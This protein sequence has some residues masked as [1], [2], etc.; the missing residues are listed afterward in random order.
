MHTQVDQLLKSFW[1][2]EAEP[3]YKQKIL[4]A[5]EQ[6]CE[7][8]YQSTTA[9]DE[10]GRY[11]VKLPFRDPQ[12]AC[13]NGN[14]REIA[15][16]RFLSLEKK[17][18]KDEHL[19]RE[20]QKIFKEYVDLNHMQEIRHTP[21][22]GNQNY[23]YLPYHAVVREDKETTKVRIVFDASC[24]GANG[25]SLN[26]DLMV[27]PSLQS[28]LRH[29]IMRWRV[30][31]ICFAADI[32]KMY[33]QVKVD[34][35]DANYQR[36]LWRENPC[37]DFKEYKLLRVTF[38]T[39]SAPYLAVKS[40]MQVAKDEGHNYPLAVERVERDF[41][42][43]D[44]MS[45]CEHEDEAIE[46]YKQMTALLLKGG[47]ELQKWTSNSESMIER[48]RQEQAGKEVEKAI[49]VK[50]ETTNKILGLTWS[51][52]TDEFLYSVQLPPISTPV[53]KRKVIS[54]I[55][56][57]YDPQ[58]WIA[59]S[60]IKA[61]IFIQKLWLAGI[62]WDE[63]V[64][65]VLLEE[66]TEFRESLIQLTNFRLKRWMNFKA[67]V[68]LVELHGF[69]DAST[70]AFGAVVYARIMDA[71]GNIHVSLVTAKTR[72]API[73]QLSIPRLELNGAVLLAK[74]LVEVSEVLKIPKTN[75]HA[76]TDSEVVLAWLS[77]HPSKWKTFIGNRVSEILTVTD[78]K[79]WSHVKSE[80]NPADYASRGLSAAE[81]VSCELWLRGPSWLKERNINYTN[82]K[83]ITTNLE[84]RIVKTHLAV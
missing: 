40:L 63:E 56:K 77:C 12:P 47:F 62:D 32:I 80:H 8:I 71:M 42:M 52:E 79:Q 35:E 67:D 30:H 68:K 41:Y 66:W 31:L 25:V 22:K 6:R 14:S 50:L 27:G 4:S 13:V 78:R 7:E 2:M 44:L 16:R 51:R 10:D 1:E 82:P 73:K 48:I 11:I 60:V 38:G 20:Y 57:L 49:L 69:S 61:K 28:E 37:D 83:G 58:G 5:E 18:R 39:S 54:D 53:T 65:P 75:I 64:P 36:I 3:S 9:R 34:E 74:L 46:I 45:G 33:R 72:V 26:D 59:P 17:L 23:S 24:K 55:S 84:E 43:D 19:K 76:W 70:A 21:G 15:L 81:L 29:I